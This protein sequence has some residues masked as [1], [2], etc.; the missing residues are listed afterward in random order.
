MASFA[1]WRTPLTAHPCHRPRVR[2]GSDAQ[3]ID[4]Y[5]N[6]GL[7]GRGAFNKIYK[8]RHRETGD[9]VALKS[10]QLAA[11][12]EAGQACAPITSPGTLVALLLAAYGPR[13]DQT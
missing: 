3:S 8:A 12:E 6:L 5:E 4:R 1:A 13:R 7:V 2:L 11:L 10:M 9:I